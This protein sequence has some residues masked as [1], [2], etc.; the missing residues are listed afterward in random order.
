MMLIALVPV[1]LVASCQAGELL[2]QAA[3]PLQ[4]FTQSQNTATGEYGFSY[5]GGPS[6][7]T[8]YRALDGT[9]TGTYSY[10]D[11]NGQLQSVSYIADEAGFRA[12]G[13]NIPQ[14]RKKRGILYQPVT[15]FAALPAA[16]S[17]QNRFQVHNDARLIQRTEIHAP[18]HQAAVAAP[19]ALHAPAA[20]L[21]R[22]KRGILAAAEPLPLAYAAAPAGLPLP[23]SSAKI[24]NEFNQQ[25]PTLYAAAAAPAPALVHAAPAAVAPIVHAAAAPIIEQAAISRSS[26]NR[27]QVHKDSKIVEE[28]HT[29]LYPTLQYAAYAAPALALQPAQLI[30]Q[31]QQH[32]FIGAAPQP[33]F[34]IGTVTAVGAP[35]S[36][37][38]PAGPIAAEPARP[39]PAPAAPA[40]P[41]AVSDDAI[42][43]ESA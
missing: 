39:A 36:Q 38:L 19:V 30:Q 35:P 5:S 22:K 32:H 29:P 12:T 17:S 23:P 26:Q 16:S 33:A 18:I 42:T 20:L 28:I 40:A 6:A 41:A 27:F 1:L 2:A 10:V 11:A 37:P 31:Q 15:A 14:A 34:G 3:E 8:E 9:T 25:R 13:T 4:Q 24:Y 43:V 7:K 21:Y